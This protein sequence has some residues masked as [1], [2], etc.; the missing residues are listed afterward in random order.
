MTNV[1]YVHRL[2]KVGLCGSPPRNEKGEQPYETSS[3]S[4]A[5]FPE[6]R[7]LHIQAPVFSGLDICIRWSD[8]CQVICGQNRVVVIRYLCREQTEDVA[9]LGL[10]NTALTAN[11][12]ILPPDEN[13]LYS[14]SEK[15]C[16]LTPGVVRDHVGLGF[17]PYT[18]SYNCCKSYTFS[19]V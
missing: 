11:L 1:R 2:I 10:T 19:C 12:P 8:Q 17:T 4:V 7:F 6:S 14:P 5:G 9:G 3:A 18:H 15:L 16:L 13:F